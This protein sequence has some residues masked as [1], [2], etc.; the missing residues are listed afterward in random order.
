[1]SRQHHLASEARAEAMNHLHKSARKMNIVR[2]WKKLLN[3]GSDVW[4]AIPL[5]AFV[6]LL[7]AL[8]RAHR[9]TKDG[10]LEFWSTR[11][12]EAL[13]PWIFICGIVILASLAIAASRR[14]RRKDHSRR[15]TALEK[16]GNNRVE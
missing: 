9:L 3:V 2:R 1:M 15:E 16:A 11:T 14:V 6:L 12:L 7:S 5:I 8:K 4:I 13:T 10:N